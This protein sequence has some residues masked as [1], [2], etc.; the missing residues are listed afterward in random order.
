[1]RKSFLYFFILCFISIFS[2]LFRKLFLD[3][4]ILEI[5]SLT[6]QLSRS[7]INDHFHIAKSREYVK[8]IILTVNIFIKVFFIALILLLGC[9]GCNKQI[10]FIDLFNISIKTEFVY[11]LPIIYES[12]FFKFIQK[13]HSYSYIQN[14]SSLSLYNLFDSD[15]IDFWFIYPL[16]TINLFE[17]FYIILLSYQLGKLTQTNIFLGLKIIR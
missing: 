11:V 3:L 5:K 16:Q 8:Y 4:D 9:I 6:N 10:K 17:F 12:F 14:F 2:L 1:M 15:K 13:N 7:Q